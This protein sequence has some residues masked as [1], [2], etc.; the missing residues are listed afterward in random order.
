MKHF[1]DLLAEACI[2]KKSA[3]CVGLDPRWA[4][5]PDVIRSGVDTGLARAAANERDGVRAEMGLTSSFVIGM[6]ARMSFQK[7]HGTLIRAFAAADIPDST[8]V[9]IGDGPLDLVTEFTDGEG[10]TG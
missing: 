4:S 7:D 9:L 3:V 2:A 8:L 6:V 10:V 1:G 5:L